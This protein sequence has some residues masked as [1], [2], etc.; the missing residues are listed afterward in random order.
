MPNAEWINESGARFHNVTQR[1]FPF[2]NSLKKNLENL[3]HANVSLCL[4]LSPRF[5]FF[6]LFFFFFFSVL[7]CF[8][9]SSLFILPFVSKS[10]NCLD[11]RSGELHEWG[12]SPKGG[13]LVYVTTSVEVN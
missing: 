7:S 9:S 10:A 12:L 3:L 8:V 4:S 1:C 11:D 2:H 13:V 6:S 5:P